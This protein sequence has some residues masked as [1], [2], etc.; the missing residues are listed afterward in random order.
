MKSIDKFNDLPSVVVQQQQLHSEQPPIMSSTV[1]TAPSEL[2]PSLQTTLNVNPL[3][4]DNVSSVPA[5]LP[6]VFDPVL[7]S[8]PETTFPVVNNLSKCDLKPTDG[9]VPIQSKWNDT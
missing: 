6:S 5:M 3:V 1:T 4:T 9:T 8:S 2:V 7:E